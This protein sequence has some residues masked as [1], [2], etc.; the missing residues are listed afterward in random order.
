[1]RVLEAWSPWV[2]SNGPVEFSPGSH[3]SWVRAVAATS[4]RQSRPPPVPGTMAVEDSI[5]S[6]C[7]GLQVQEA[8]SPNGPVQKV[9]MGLWSVVCGQKAEQAL[10]G[11]RE[12][13]DCSLSPSVLLMNTQK[14][15]PRSVCEL[16]LPL[17]L[18]TR[19]FGPAG[20]NACHLLLSLRPSQGPAILEAPVL[21]ICHPWPG[22]PG[23]AP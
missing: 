11:I 18:P 9:V 10:L 21:L 16:K 8:Q 13:F 12:G 6:S 4:I 23:Q 22:A 3:R 5:C 7:Q 15:R 1:M 17:H 19:L 20:L 14:L 2:G